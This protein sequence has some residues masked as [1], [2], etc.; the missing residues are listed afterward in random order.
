MPHMH[1]LG[2]EI[3]V[4]MTPPDGKP[5]TLVDIKDWDYNWQETYFFKE[6]IHAQGRHE[7]R[8]R[9]GLRQQRQ[10]P[11][12]PVQPAAA[13]FFG[14][15]TTNEM[16]FVFFGVTSA[17][18]TEAR[19]SPRRTVPPKPAEDEVRTPIPYDRFSTVLFDAIFGRCG[20]SAFE[21]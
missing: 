3:K 4:T 6:P 10:E 19:Q 12:Q 17:G 1:M 13:V 2:K 20:P 11:E 21:V 18:P 8:R 5:T 15:Q 14:E 16:C 7:A 9:G